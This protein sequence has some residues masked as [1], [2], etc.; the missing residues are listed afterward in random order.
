MASLVFAIPILS[1]K[2]ETFKDMAEETNGPLRSQFEAFQGSHGVYKESW[3]F[4]QA[5]H[6]DMAV[7]YFEADDPARVLQQI[8]ESEEPFLKRFKEKAL[9]QQ[10]LQ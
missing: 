4:Q 1:G 6:G 9:G 3:Y 7:I 10:K 8:A 2:T 5:S